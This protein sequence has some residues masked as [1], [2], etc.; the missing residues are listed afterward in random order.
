MMGHWCAGV[1]DIDKAYEYDNGYSDKLLRHRRRMLRSHA[2]KSFSEA[3]RRRL[4]LLTRTLVVDYRVVLREFDAGVPY[5]T[6]W[7]KASFDE[8][9]SALFD[10]DS[11]SVAVVRN[12]RT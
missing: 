3:S 5:L 10:E 7:D 9:I 4:A 11:F 12:M 2:T 6:V 1:N 8:V